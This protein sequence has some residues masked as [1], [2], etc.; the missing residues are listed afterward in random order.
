MKLNAQIIKIN[1]FMNF[2]PNPDII[3]NRTGETIDIY[4]DMEATDGKIS[5]L[6][7]ARRNEALR[8]NFHILPTGQDKVDE[9]L[10]KYWNIEDL[11]ALMT[12]LMEALQFGFKP[13]EI[14][15]KQVD[16]Y[17]V[18]DYYRGLP[19]EFFEF[20]RD[21]E[22][23]FN[24][25]GA[26]QICNNP[27]RFIV[28][29]NGGTKYDNPYGKSLYSSC[30]WPWQFKRAGF[31][32]WMQA[33]ELLGV[34]SVMAIFDSQEGDEK[35]AERASLLAN[36]LANISSGSAGALA[37]VKEIK[38][39]TMN[40]VLK[41]F[42]TIIRACNE[43]ISYAITGQTLATGESQYGSRAQ[44]DV[45]ERTFAS[46]TGQ[47]ARG[48]AF[49][50]QQLVEWAVQINFPGAE[51]PKVIADVGDYAPWEQVKDAIDRKIPV[52]KASLYSR[53][54]LPIPDPKDKDDI[55]LIPDDAPALSSP[56]L[57]LS[58]VAS[59]RSFFLRTNHQ[60]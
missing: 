41:D 25:N 50:I 10:A 1:Q 33:E 27:Y 39:I 35:T 46:F 36:E 13:A 34:P 53:Y 49:T 29:R 8:T 24:G 9:Y 7:G 43:E 28:H 2:M 60:R 30:Y 18:L 44:A 20:D 51:L 47:D 37:N 45:H 48:L 31:Q 38:Q 19:T 12:D 3:L 26:R 21:G 6:T 55:F 5:S 14:Y 4:K 22:M 32:F 42:N 40:S 59:G 23:Y 11:F 16:G 54:G 58:D 15:W 17:Y 52:S 56:T 57:N